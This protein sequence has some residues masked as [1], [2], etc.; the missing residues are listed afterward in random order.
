V[1]SIANVGSLTSGRENRKGDEVVN[2]QQYHAGETIEATFDFLYGDRAKSVTATFAHTQDPS[3][4]LQLSGTPEE[5]HA[6]GESGYSYWHVVLSGDVTAENKLGT[7]R[8][9]AVEA[10]YPGGRKVLFG[11][12][13]DIGLE[14]AEE[15]IP[16]PE[17]LGD[18]E[19][20]K[21][22]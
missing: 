1:L 5:H 7:Y 8:C 10:E 21:Q 17:I 9:E 15:E 14:I 19:W 6:T 13:P 20:S 3:I 11:G 16:P 4:K 2:G 22:P 12:V 18:W